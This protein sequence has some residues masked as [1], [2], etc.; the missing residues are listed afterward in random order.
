[1]TGAS[2]VHF[3]AFQH[4]EL[5]DYRGE[6]H[7]AHFA[8][9]AGTPRHESQPIRSTTFCSQCGSNVPSPTKDDNEYMGIL[10][11]L[12][13]DMPAHD[14]SFHFYTKSKMPWIQIPES[15]PQALT[16]KEGYLDPDQ[17]DLER[18]LE[19]NHI[20]G[21]C[22]CG[23]VSFIASEPLRMMNCHCTRCRLA[24]TAAHATN[25]FVLQ[26]N[27]EW[28]TGKEKVKSY[29]LPEADR[30]SQA[31]CGDCG[32]A[33]PRDNPDPKGPV[34]I[35]AGCLDSDPGTTPQ[36]HIYVN[37]KAPWFS[38][39]DNLPRWDERPETQADS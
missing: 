8:G 37:S 18:H 4:P 15:E 14:G 30:F 17:P 32:S 28:R 35:P 24:R 5:V 21:S 20:T 11:G 2:Y 13:L 33:V 12:I 34:N 22:L 6:Q 10:A 26:E 7:L 16:V 19:E 31:F 29:K 36:G 3:T 25:L 27:F 39:F 38:F 23:A 1:M 9:T